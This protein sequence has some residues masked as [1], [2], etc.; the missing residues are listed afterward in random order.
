MPH[1]CRKA[2]PTIKLVLL[3]QVLLVKGCNTLDLILILNLLWMRLV[4]P[5][6]S[7]WP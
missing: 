1:S 5:T 7:N 3:L 4:C 2:T 6:F